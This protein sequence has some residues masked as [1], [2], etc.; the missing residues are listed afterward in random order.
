MPCLSRSPPRM[1]LKASGSAGLQRSTLSIA[2]YTQSVTRLKA[3][4]S[5]GFQLGGDA[6]IVRVCE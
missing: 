6:L 5:A 4:G 3:S 1:R 2:R